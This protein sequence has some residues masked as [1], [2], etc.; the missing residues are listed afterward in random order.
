MKTNARIAIV[1]LTLVL[2]WSFGFT[3]ASA[4]GGRV[5]Y[6]PVWFHWDR[7]SLDVL[8]LPP[9]HGQLVN[10]EGILAGGDLRELT[11]HANSYVDAIE[12]SV[13]D[14]SRGVQSFGPSWLRSGLQIQA[15]VVGR[16]SIPSASLLNP[17]I[18]IVTDETKGPLLGA[19][20]ATRP[21]VVD[22]SKM[23]LTSYTYA[24]MYSVNAHEVGHCLGLSHVGG[25]DGFRIR[26]DTMHATYVH[27]PG[28]AG[29]HRHCVSNLN[30]AG[31]ERV[32]GP[33][34]GRT[35]ASPAALDGSSYERIA[36]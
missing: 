1:A 22:N 20:V 25:A 21:C 12:R 9:G 35:G 10:G 30:V 17:E 11:P 19:A 31:L 6:Q 28:A 18:V 14:W 4:D 29:T 5:L 7:A 26:H 36:C 8:I 15:Y 13:K 34:F 16:D 24:D 32:F 33:L 27:E 2:G 23:Y 3:G